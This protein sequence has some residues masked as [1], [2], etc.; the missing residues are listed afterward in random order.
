MRPSTV[1]GLREQLADWKA[2]QDEGGP[3]A[4]FAQ[5]VIEGIERKLSLLNS[6][7]EA[8][9]GDP[10]GF[11]L[12]SRSQDFWG[13]ILPDASDVGRYRWQG[14]RADG[15]TGHCTFDTPEL[16]LG[17]MIDS[18]LEIPD[19]GALDRHA[20]TPTWLRGM[21]MLA[22]V[23]ACNSGLISWDESCKKREEISARYEQ[24]A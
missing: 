20:N 1:E 9:K 6:M 11:T 22:V 12:K 17:D 10:L 15:F 18:G 13:V 24:A 8:F 2:Q 19:Q 14:F 21:E 23:Q 4:H 5:E 16:C 7:I 3:L